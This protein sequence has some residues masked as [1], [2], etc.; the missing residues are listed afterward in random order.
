MRAAAVSNRP[1]LLVLE[2]RLAFLPTIGP[3]AAVDDDGHVRVVLVVLDHLVVELVGE[4]A[5]NDAIDHRPLIVGRRPADTTTGAG[6]RGRCCAGTSG[7]SR[8]SPVPPLP[9]GSS[10]RS[11]SAAARLRTAHRRRVTRSSSPRPR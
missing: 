1:L 6:I 5:G 9:E 3:F 2:P 10:P 7:G 11:R 8:R 4:L